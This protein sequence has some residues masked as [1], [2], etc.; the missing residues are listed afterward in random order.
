MNCSPVSFVPDPTVGLVGTPPVGAPHCEQNLALPQLL[1]H[2]VQKTI[3]AEAV[4]GEPVYTEEGGGRGS[5]QCKTD[6]DPV[7][8]SDAAKEG[9]VQFLIY[10]SQLRGLKGKQQMTTSCKEFPAGI[11]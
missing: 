8:K 3:T 9:S 10:S 1:P 5:S 2:A 7:R 6:N 4:G 11:T